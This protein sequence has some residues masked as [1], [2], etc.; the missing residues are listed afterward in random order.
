MMNAN[1]RDSHRPPP[2]R[3]RAVRS[4]QQATTT[5]APVFTVTLDGS[6]RPAIATSASN[7]SININHNTH[8]RPRSRRG[9]GPA[10]RRRRSGLP[11]GLSPPLLPGPTSGEASA[12]SAPPTALPAHETHTILLRFW[13]VDPEGADETPR[14]E[15]PRRVRLQ[16]AAGCCCL[17]KLHLI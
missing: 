6:A 10:H 15:F 8:R 12:D 1:L 2:R 16:A 3:S 14:L 17:M 7:T 5:E 11:P 4:M 9:S 13:V